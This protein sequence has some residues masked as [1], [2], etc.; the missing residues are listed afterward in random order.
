MFCLRQN[1]DLVVDN[2][3]KTSVYTLKIICNT[4]DNNSFYKYNS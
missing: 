2:R 1:Y 3:A 4:L